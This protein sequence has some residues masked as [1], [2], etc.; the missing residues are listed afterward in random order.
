MDAI[1][2]RVSDHYLTIIP[3]TIDFVDV[4]VF[5]QC[6]HVIARGLIVILQHLF[7][8][9]MNPLGITFEPG[10]TRAQISAEIVRLI[11]QRDG[12]QGFYRGYV[13][14]LCAYVPNS[15][16]WWGLYT[17][18]QGKRLVEISVYMSWNVIVCFS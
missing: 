11:Y 8:F 14:S 3:V 10:K 13:A 2:L 16:L 5:S 15:A 12:Y 17:V 4:I 7:Q 9:G 18:Y 1:F 6:I